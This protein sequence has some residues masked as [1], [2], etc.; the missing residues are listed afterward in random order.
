MPPSSP[1]DLAFANKVDAWVSGALA[2]GKRT[3]GEVL[4]ALPGVYP[5]EVLPSLRRITAA[6]GLRPSHL[7]AIERGASRRH[8][9]LCKGNGLGWLPL[10]HPL[11]FEWRF[12]AETCETLLARAD[13]LS[14]RDWPVALIGTPGLCAHL[15]EHGPIGRP[16]SFLGENNVVTG[17]LRHRAL[18]GPAK[19]S[20]LPCGAGSSLAGTAD[21][22]IIDPPWYA[23]YI[24]PLFRMAALVCRVGG[25]ILVSLP[26]EGV[27]PSAWADRERTLAFARRIGLRAVACEPRTLT[28]DTPF[29]EWNS[30]VAAGIRNLPLTWRRGDLLV[31]ERMPAQVAPPGK[32]WVAAGW[33]ESVVKGVRFRARLVTA[34]PDRG[35]IAAGLYPIVDGGVLPSVS[36]RDPRRASVDVWTSGNRVF[37][38]GRPDLVH[39]ACRRLLGESPPD[40]R[41]KSR[42]AGE[43]AYVERI[44]SDLSH[45]VAQELMELTAFGA[46]EIGYTRP[47]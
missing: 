16:F 45:V 43:E 10:P 26:S 29:F 17:A 8:T 5:T 47:R 20:F 3:F 25:H 28:Y 40:D 23:D 2:D 44:A 36:R 12:S 46:L 19:I 35:A 1:E 18:R 31:F 6:G 13:G 37:R 33:E 9:P 7:S 4:C 11:D 41:G 27:R 24:R 21:A 38:C 39:L 32:Q 14:R 34:A 30:L 15:L 22:V 42:D